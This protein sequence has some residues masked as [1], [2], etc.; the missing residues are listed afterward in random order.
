MNEL[1]EAIAAA[2]PDR[3]AVAEAIWEHGTVPVV[4]NGQELQ[5]WALEV[6]VVAGQAASPAD[7]VER[8]EQLLVDSFGVP[9]D[10]E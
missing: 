4:L 6:G 10:D 8:Y 5:E 3:K 2:W 1:L 9:P 7:A